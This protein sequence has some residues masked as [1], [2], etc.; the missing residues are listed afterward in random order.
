MPPNP[1]YWKNRKGW[2]LVV[3]RKRKGT[4]WEEINY[5]GNLEAAPEQKP[6]AGAERSADGFWATLVTEREEKVWL[7]LRPLRVRRSA[8]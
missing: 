1:N 2:R 5:I 7:L 6:A 4:E 3:H 8:R